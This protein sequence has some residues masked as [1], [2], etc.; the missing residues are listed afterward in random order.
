[1]K[2]A[3]AEERT[4]LTFDR[5]Y[6]ELIFKYGYRPPK[7]IVYFRWS[8]YQPEAPAQFLMKILEENEIAIEQIFTVIDTDSI[9]Q[10]KYW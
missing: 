10:Q 7:G 6:G 9:R 1:M 2:I 4:I 3:I 8:S 5:Y